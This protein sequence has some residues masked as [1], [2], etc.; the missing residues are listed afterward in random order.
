MRDINLIIEKVEQKLPDIDVWQPEK[1]YPSDDNGI[2]YF[3]L[4]DVE[5]D[6]QIESSFGCCPFIV[7]TEEQSSY[8]ARTATTVDEAVEMIVE[9]LESKRKE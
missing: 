2:W 6:I 7:E 4:P 5:P 8:D 3:R 9:Y 1:I